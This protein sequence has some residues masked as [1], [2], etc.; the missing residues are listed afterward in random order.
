MTF[1]DKVGLRLPTVSA[2]VDPGSVERFR[3]AIGGTAD[4]LVPLT[5]LFALEMQAREAQASVVDLLDLDLSRILHGEQDF[6]YKRP[7]RIGDVVSFETCI[8]GVSQKR[9]GE[10]WVFDIASKALNTAGELLALTSRRIVY[11]SPPA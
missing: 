9:D 5:Y 8:R 10:L 7:V 6:T 11:R 2:R 4:A 3:A 1:S